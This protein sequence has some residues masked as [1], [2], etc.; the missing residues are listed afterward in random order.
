M[1]ILDFIKEIAD[2]GLK[3][4]TGALQTEIER[5]FGSKIKEIQKAIARQLVVIFIMLISLCLIVLSLTFFLIDYLN[6]NKTL[7]FL[8]IGIFLSLI[9]L[10]IKLWR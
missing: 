9:S 6:I 3:K 2:F 5:S 7:S 4:V 10:I 1:N 8:I